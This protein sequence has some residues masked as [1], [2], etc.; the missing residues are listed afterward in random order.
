MT[1]MTETKSE[2]TGSLF[3]ALDIISAGSILLE[4]VE[5]SLQV[6]A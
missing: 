6:N 5:D 1:G 4:A 3:N 2:P